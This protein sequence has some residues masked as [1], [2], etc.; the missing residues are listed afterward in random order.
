MLYS[1]LLYDIHTILLNKYKALKYKFLA[2][3]ILTQ[4]KVYI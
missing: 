3:L 4:L 1:I 2:Q